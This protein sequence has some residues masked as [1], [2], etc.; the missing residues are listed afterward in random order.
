M[1]LS[2]DSKGRDCYTIWGG[3]WQHSG[4]H[5]EIARGVIGKASDCEVFLAGHFVPAYPGKDAVIG[6]VLNPPKKG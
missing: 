2:Q 5:F 3:S 1:S 4:E 6:A